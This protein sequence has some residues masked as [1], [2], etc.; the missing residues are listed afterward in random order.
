MYDASMLRNNKPVNYSH[1]F[2]VASTYVRWLP[3][4]SLRHMITVT[5]QI[6]EKM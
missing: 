5:V 4:I 3:F 1:V 2:S 6:I